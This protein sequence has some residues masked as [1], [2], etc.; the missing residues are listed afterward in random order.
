MSYA[1]NEAP[2]Y[3]AGHEVTDTWMVQLAP[4]TMEDFKRE[5][6]AYSYGDPWTKTPVGLCA[7][8]WDSTRAPE[9]KHVLYLYHYEPYNLRGGAQRWDEIKEQVADECFASMSA[10]ATNLTSRQRHRPLGQ[11][12]ARPGAPRPVV[13]PGQLQPHRL[14]AHPAV[15]QPA[16]R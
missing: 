2:K 4:D 10:H 11:L 5:F 8:K 13:D 14:A 1:L 15:R 7:T 9:G 6:D 16:V 12:P 3:K